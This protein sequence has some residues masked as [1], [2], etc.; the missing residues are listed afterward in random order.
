MKGELTTTD[1]MMGNFAVFVMFSIML[2]WMASAVLPIF[3]PVTA[4]AITAQGRLDSFKVTAKTTLQSV[5]FAQSCLSVVIHNDGDSVVHVWI[6]SSEG[7]PAQLGA[8][9]SLPVDYGWQPVIMTVFY[10][11]PSGESPIRIIGAY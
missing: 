4:L 5:V 10:Q 6:N 3:T 1:G 9:E 2:V 7:N 8:G 11:T